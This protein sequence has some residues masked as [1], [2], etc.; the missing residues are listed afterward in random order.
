MGN[1]RRGVNLWDT[2]SSSSSNN[3]SQKVYE[4]NEFEDLLKTGDYDLSTHS[5]RNAF[6]DDYRKRTGKGLSNAVRRSLKNYYVNGT[7]TSAKHLNRIK[8]FNASLS[9]APKYYVQNGKILKEGDDGWTQV[10]YDNAFKAG[11]GGNDYNT[12]VDNFNNKVL[13]WRKSNEGLTYDPITNKYY[14]Q[15][16]Y[17]PD[18]KVD[19]TNLSWAK[20]LINGMADQV[21]K[22]Q[23]DRGIHFDPATQQ[24][25]DVNKQEA[26]D[27][28]MTDDYKNGLINQAYVNAVDNFIPNDNSLGYWG[29]DANKFAEFLGV[30]VSDYGTKTDDE[31]EKIRAKVADALKIKLQQLNFGADNKESWTES[32]LADAW[33]KNLQNKFG[34]SNEW[35]SGWMQGLNFGMSNRYENAQKSGT[36]SQVTGYGTLGFSRYNKQGGNLNCKKQIL[37]NIKEK[38]LQMN[39]TNYYQAGGQIAQG[40]QNMEAQI[41]QLVQAAMS[42]DQKAAQTI[43]QIM[44]AAKQGDQQAAQLAQM[45]QQVAQQLQGQAQSAKRGA[46]LSYLKSLRS[47]CP[48]GTEAKY[49]KKGGHLCKECVSKVKKHDGGDNIVGNIKE[50]THGT[51][52]AKRAGKST[53]ETGEDYRKE[54]IPVSINYTPGVEDIAVPLGPSMMLPGRQAGTM[55]VEGL[56]PD[57]GAVNDTT[58]YQGVGPFK[59]VVYTNNINNSATGRPNLTQ[60]A[61]R[62]LYFQE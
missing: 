34:T 33:L 59:R 25:V 39:R 46:K 12:I 27:A 22:L 28:W 53:V 11:L 37:E 42:G 61:R 36:P 13:D 30:D 2:I 38:H 4:G 26:T 48:E 51:I 20:D 56:Y 10:D 55:V 1:D 15:G 58:I 21:K 29:S 50:Q 60:A 40:N 16:F 47:G 45:I 31:K 18:Q 41:A 62:T 3:S 5:G 24:F 54:T 43:Q 52:K 7:D 57:V 49:F 17:N 32:V 9:R 23:K 44:D 6:E 14:K 8:T 35:K 19:I